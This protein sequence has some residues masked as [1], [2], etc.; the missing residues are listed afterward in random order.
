MFCKVVSLT[1]LTVALLAGQS[2]TGKEGVSSNETT[3]SGASQ[4]QH[5][6]AASLRKAEETTQPA[7]RSAALV[8]ARAHIEAA[9]GLQPD[10]PELLRLSAM[11][12]LLRNEAGT[13]LSI[14][15]QLLKR[16]ADNVGNYMLAADAALALRRYPEA[17][18][19]IDWMLRLRPQDP[20]TLDRV[21]RF[22]ASQNDH[23]GAIEAFQLARRATPEEDRP[24]QA[25][26]LHRLGLSALALRRHSE[27]RELLNA[28]ARDYPPA[29]LT[30]R[31]LG[32]P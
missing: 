19:M 12:H 30:L 7:A 5:A 24:A 1:I 16:N 20:R 14:A 31:Q 6:A 26:L 10:H 22:R 25:R 17:E 3:D 9:R 4:E 18:A 11:L 13:A 23:E 32:K 15:Q 27:A 2:S 21:G 8:Q 28:A 29:A